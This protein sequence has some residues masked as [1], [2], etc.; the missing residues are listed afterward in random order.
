M[1]DDDLNKKN[2]NAGETQVVVYHGE[3]RKKWVLEMVL[4]SS[5]SKPG[6][7]GRRFRAVGSYGYMLSDQEEQERRNIPISLSGGRK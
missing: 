6:H 4:P 7:S 1:L 2:N 5:N 3:K